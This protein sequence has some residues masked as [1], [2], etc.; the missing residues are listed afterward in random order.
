MLSDVI[1][2]SVHNCSAVFFDMPG[3][4]SL[5]GLQ[6]KSCRSVLL[7]MFLNAKE[8]ISVRKMASGDCRFL[9]N[10]TVILPVM[11]LKTSN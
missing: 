3:S 10:V 2:V 8:I 6:S 9:R 1:E 11:S 5:W 7:N 4:A